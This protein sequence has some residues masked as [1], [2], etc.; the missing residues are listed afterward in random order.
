[1][2][3]IRGLVWFLLLGVGTWIGLRLGWSPVLSVVF[4]ALMASM[5]VLFESLFYRLSPRDLAAIGVGIFLGVGIANLVAALT[6][7]AFH[8]LRRVSDLWFVFWNVVGVYFFGSFFYHHRDRFRFARSLFRIP[9]GCTPKIID[10]SAII[11]GRLIGVV[12]T[13]FLEG[14]LIIPR[15][16]VQELQ[17]IADAKEPL[18]RAKGRRGMDLLKELQE[19]KGIRVMVIPDEVPG[20]REVDHKLIAVAKRRR[21][22]LVTV[23]YNL[24]KAAQIQGVPV[25]NLNALAQELRPQ[26]LPGDRMTIFVQRQG[27]EPGQG[28][29]YLE[30]GTMVVVEEGEHLIGQTIHAEVVTLLQ[31]DAGRIIFVRPLTKKEKE[32]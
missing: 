9:R 8:D 2:R 13:G 32:T 28:V 7:M 22:K 17:R 4:S 26:Y 11:D 16:V 6:L 3:W 29:G 5:V 10:T 23:D 27:K 25:L 30:D 20:I 24:N 12:R 14:D 15:F 19:M 1:M 21:G 31:T 18:R